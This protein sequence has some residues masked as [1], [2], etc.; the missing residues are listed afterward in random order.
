MLGGWLFDC[1]A[2]YGDDNPLYNYV[3]RDN[4]VWLD[5]DYG[6]NRRDTNAITSLRSPQP[7]QIEY[8]VSFGSVSEPQSRYHLWERESGGSRISLLTNRNVA[9]GQTYIANGRFTDD[10]SITGWNVRC[11]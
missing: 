9:T 8:V 10:G 11:R 2:P 3:W 1:N 4:Q 6:G 7:N 5:R